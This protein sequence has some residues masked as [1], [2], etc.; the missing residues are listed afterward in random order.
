MINF[1]KDTQIKAY[2]GKIEEIV[3]HLQNL[4]EDIG[5]AQLAQTVSD[6]RSRVSDPYMFVI[7]G[8]VKAGK[9]S[10]INALLGTGEEICKVA[11]SPM[12]DTIQ[13]IVYGEEEKEVTLNPYL[14]R[15]YQP[16]EILREISIV[17]TPG[18]NTIV[19]HHQEITERFIPGSDLIVFVFESKNPYRQSA[20]DFF[21]YIHAD[22]RKK[23][24]FVLQQK[25]LMEP[26]DL[27]INIQGVKDFAKKNGIDSPLVFAVSAKAELEG[28]Q[29]ESGYT[30]L[31]KYIEDNITGGQAPLLKLE[32][33]IQSSWNIHQRIQTGVKDR[34]DQFK[35][36]LA[37]RDDISNTLDE[38]EGRSQ[39]MVDS[40]VKNLL[41]SYDQVTQAK[42]RELE[43]G[44]GFGSLIGRSLRSI[45]SK[46][47]SAKVWLQGISGGL[48]QELKKQLGARLDTGVNDIAESIQQM[49]K[50]IDLKTRSS[51]T[52]LKNDHDLFSTIAEKRANVLKDLRAAFSK[53]LEHGENFYEPGLLPE[54][55]KITPQLAAGGGVAVIGALLTYLTNLSV[56]DV[57]GGI[58]TAVGLV[59]AGVTIGWNRRKILAG[60]RK[61]ISRG[62]ETLR[63]DVTNKL[64]TYIRHIKEKIDANFE[65][66][67]K[68]L[69]QEKD[70]VKILNEKLDL[71]S[72]DLKGME[73]T[74]KITDQN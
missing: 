5:H 44:L 45:F 2:Q 32:S 52:I 35:A 7:V 62:R 11:P 9:S 13:Q 39:Q 63:V 10:F 18:T 17:D 48:E 55:S 57:T 61:E 26:A 4:T 14:K 19:D 53:F 34:E 68:M 25:D 1:F 38:Q 58:L 67:D 8:E 66:F 72:Q 37:F 50:M 33:N 21:K 74:L 71:I 40:L 64:N 41:T 29:E 31:R 43:N 28:L 6:L 59:F 56:L 36:D 27:E 24:I 30:P 69:A 12:T 16:V 3:K 60:F 65:G 54:D 51:S 15:I 47:A 23:I 70:A 46:E 42:D 20:W 22:W 73:G 49:A